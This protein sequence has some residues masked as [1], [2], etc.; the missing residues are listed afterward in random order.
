MVEHMVTLKNQILSNILENG[1]W[2]DDCP[3]I[4]NNGQIAG[5]NIR[6]VYHDLLMSDL[7]LQV[8]ECENSQGCT[9]LIITATNCTTDKFM[10]KIEFL[11]SKL[12]SG[13]IDT[14]LNGAS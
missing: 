8:Y 6:A 4:K 13:E 12:T 2:V 3:T 9:V 11:S 7:G 14:L 5:A 10:S 1:Y